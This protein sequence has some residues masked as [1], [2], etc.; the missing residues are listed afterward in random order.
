M[1][2]V[3]KGSPAGRVGLREGDIVVGFAGEPVAGVDDL[4]RL[5]TVRRVGVELPLVVLRNSARREL[6]V[7]PALAPGAAKS[8]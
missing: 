4:H 6:S 1:L 8:R 5:L 2:S 7:T 3:D